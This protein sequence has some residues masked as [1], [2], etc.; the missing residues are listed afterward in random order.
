LGW[1][2]LRSFCYIK[3]LWNDQYGHVKEAE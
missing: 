3:E 2:S 1:F